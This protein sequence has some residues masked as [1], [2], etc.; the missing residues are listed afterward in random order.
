MV[1][2]KFGDYVPSP[3]VRKEMYEVTISIF[4]DGTKNNKNNSDARDNND[5]SYSKYGKSAASSYQNYWTNVA[6]LWECYSDDAAEH[7]LYIE[8]IGTE[9]YEKD[10]F[11]GYV[12]GAGKTGIPAKMRKACDQVAEILKD[13]RGSFNKKTLR[14]VT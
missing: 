5:S 6:R 1:N 11:R 8:G 9:D 2:I 10:E 12:Y 13:L 4:F 14:T 3:R 7:C